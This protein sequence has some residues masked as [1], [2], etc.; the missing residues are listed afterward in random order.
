MFTVW[1][2]KLKASENYFRHVYSVNEPGLLEA[3]ISQG[4]GSMNQKAFN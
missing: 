1:P 3:E 2:G 4:W